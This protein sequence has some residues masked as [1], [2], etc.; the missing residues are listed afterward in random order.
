MQT[1]KESNSVQA[2]YDVFPRKR[3]GSSVGVFCEDLGFVSGMNMA[4][5]AVG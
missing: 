1:V 5:D 3:E 2:A 4:W